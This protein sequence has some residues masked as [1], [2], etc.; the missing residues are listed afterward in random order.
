MNAVSIEELQ[1]NWADF[2]DRAV[3]GEVLLITKDGRAVA[4]LRPLPSASTPMAEVLRR[5][6]DLPPIDPVQFR[7]DVDSLLDMTL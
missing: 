7:K 6:A 4:E 2:V 1:A 3:R 5:A